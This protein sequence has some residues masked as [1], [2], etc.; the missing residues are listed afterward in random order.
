MPVFG[1]AIADYF[2]QWINL[3]KAYTFAVGCWPNSGGLLDIN[4]GLNLQHTGWPQGSIAD[5]K[6]IANI[7]ETLAYQGFIVKQTSKPFCLAKDRTGQDGAW[8]SPKSF[9]P[10]PEGK[11]ESGPSLPCGLVPW[12]RAWLLDPFGAGILWPHPFPST[13]AQY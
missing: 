12:L 4:K 13:L 5:C 7:V 9:F 8:P 3:K 10:S 11:R 2:Q 6:N 1:L